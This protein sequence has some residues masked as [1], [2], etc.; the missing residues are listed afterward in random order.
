[1]YESLLHYIQKHSETPISTSV[2]YYF[3]ENLYENKKTQGQN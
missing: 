1:M 2:D 3:Y